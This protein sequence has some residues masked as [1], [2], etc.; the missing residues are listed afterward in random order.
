MPSLQGTFLIW[1]VCEV[2]GALCSSVNQGD[3][4]F[5]ILPLERVWGWGMSK[6]PGVSPQGC[7]VSISHVLPV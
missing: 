4:I 1:E 7:T 2:Q 3:L 6:G 5:L